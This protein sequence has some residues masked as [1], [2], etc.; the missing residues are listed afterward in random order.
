M[1]LDLFRLSDDKFEKMVAYLPR[2][3]RGKPPVGQVADFK[4]ALT[5]LDEKHF[6]QW[7]GGE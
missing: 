3:T 1:N 7:G 5:P 4:S 6:A 2:D